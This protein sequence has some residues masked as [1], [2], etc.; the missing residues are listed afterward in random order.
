MPA[1]QLLQPLFLLALLT[2][3]LIALL[4]LI[5]ERRKRVAVP[6]LALWKNVPRKPEGRRLNRLPLTLLLLLHLLIAALLAI[7]LAR[8][9]LASLLP[10]RPTHTA[11][12]IDTS[13]S[14]GA[15]NGTSR[16]AEAQSIARDLL[17][18]LRG[19][20]RLTLLTMGPEARAIDSGGPADL[21]RLSTA[22]DGL[23]AGGTGSN[24]DAA[25]TLAQAALT[26]EHDG[27]VVVLSDGAFNA[28]D[29]ERR[30]IA[31]VTW[32]QVGATADNRA[33]VA[34]AAR[35]WSGDNRVQLYARVANYSNRPELLPLELLRDGQQIDQQQVALEPNGQS[36]LTWTLPAGDGRV[37]ARIAGGD[38]LPADDSAVLQ[39]APRRPIRVVLVSEEPATLSR[40]LDALPE[41]QLDVLAPGTYTTQPADLTI[42]DGVAAPDPLPP[43]G[44]LVV[45][46][47]E[48]TALFAIERQGQLAPSDLVAQGPLLDG[49]SL[50]G[51]D[52]GTVSRVAPPAWG[53]MILAAEERNGGATVPLIM[54]GRSGTSEVA[55]WTF[56]LRQGNLRTRL[57]FP[58]LLARAVRDLTPPSLPATLAAG[59]VLQLR[60]SPRADQIELRSP[61]GT[62]TRQQ[63][64]SLVAFE[65]LSLP[66]SYEVREQ[67]GSETVYAGTVTVN[68]GAAIESDLRPR[69]APSL[70]AEQAASGTLA[71]RAEGRDL[72]PWL[73]ALALVALLAEWLYTQRPWARSTRQP[74]GTPGG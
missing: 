8:P 16:L 72:W 31:P 74:S 65:A 28:G 58:L 21:A 59:S 36:E 5:R 54:R 67:A 43:G 23:Q 13:S 12:I 7:G 29:A 19:E 39:L 18:R 26:P 49:L 4:H 1:M 68:A 63:A 61:D 50:G 71:A 69:P 9:Q 17:R 3:P 66:G 2:L 32:R 15:G 56:G 47:P 48:S 70:V 41:A 14:M 25:L 53:E 35:P 34:F 20:D 44:V 62:T 52:F 45:N 73:A 60:P 6:S 64:A 37:E 42:F 46:P 51:V 57:A 22:V 10:G 38:S 33:I 27:R 11:L 24:L 30:V 55:I 40:A